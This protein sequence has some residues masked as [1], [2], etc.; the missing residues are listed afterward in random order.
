[1]TQ[2]EII[3]YDIF[4]I[5]GNLYAKQK[6][7]YNEKIRSSKSLMKI[8]QSLIMFLLALFRRHRVRPMLCI[9][10]HRRTH[11]F[12]LVI[13]VDTIYPNSFQIFSFNRYNIFNACILFLFV[14]LS[15]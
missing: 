9:Y 12:I 6:V 15:K 10:V 11:T 2:R 1:M 3:F 13:I 4:D 8:C 7:V 14:H 5:Y